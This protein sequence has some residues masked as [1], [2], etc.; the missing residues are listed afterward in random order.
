M[1][2]VY[3]NKTTETSVWIGGHNDKEHDWLWPQ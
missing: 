1:V 2:I 3:Q